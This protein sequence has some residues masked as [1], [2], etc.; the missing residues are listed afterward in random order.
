MSPLALALLL[1]AAPTALAA[2][3]PAAPARALIEK[4]GAGDRSFLA[5]DHRAALFAYQDAIYLDPTSAVARIRLARAY[6]ALGHKEQAAQQLKQALELDPGNA[7]AQRLADALAN[8]SSPPVIGVGPPPV[9]ATPPA[10]KV[11]RLTDEVGEPPVAA[12]VAPPATDPQA[13]S[14]H[15]RNAVAMI[16]DRDFKGAVVELDQAILSNP[17]LGVAF[18]ARAS[19]FHGMGRFQEAVRDYQAAMQLAPELAA[20]LYGLAEAYRQLQDPRAGDYFARYAESE[21]SDVRPDLRRTAR[22]RAIQLGSR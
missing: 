18:V 5:G 19:A 16:A 7:E 9:Q 13:A 4:M 21:A 20:P 1:L 15:Y 17:Q 8:P 2:P 12:A 11:Y 3:L 6:S 22:E 10:Q 14:R